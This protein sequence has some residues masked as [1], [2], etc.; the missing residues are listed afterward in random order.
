MN[1]LLFRKVANQAVRKT[2][3]LALL[4]SGPQLCLAH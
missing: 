1:L 4:I 2:A 3:L